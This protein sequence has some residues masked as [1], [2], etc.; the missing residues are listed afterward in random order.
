MLTAI[1]HASGRPGWRH[2]RL[3]AFL[4]AEALLIVLLLVVVGT[5]VIPLAAP[6][7]EVPTPTPVS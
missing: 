5:V 1:M 3:L 2:L 4:L 6:S 7:V